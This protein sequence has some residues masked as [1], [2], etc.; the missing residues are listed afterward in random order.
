MRRFLFLFALTGMLGSATARAD[1]FVARASLDAVQDRVVELVNEARAQS[2]RCGRERHGPAAPLTVS[3]KLERAA[4]GHARDMAKRK[5]FDHRAPDGSQPRDRVQRTGYRW[6]LTGENIAFGPESAEEV[7]AGWLA[8]PGHCENIMD[9]RF[10]EIGVGVA[11]GRQRGH[12]Y[13]VQSFGS[14]APAKP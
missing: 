11:E 6:R 14:P 5:Y 13:W 12:I 4:Q 7:V 1:L 9:D 3:R 8:S 10:Q 2:R